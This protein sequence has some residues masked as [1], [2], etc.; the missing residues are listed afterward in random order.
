MYI[1]ILYVYVDMCICIHATIG[2][3]MFWKRGRNQ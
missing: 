2:L 3:I 1:L